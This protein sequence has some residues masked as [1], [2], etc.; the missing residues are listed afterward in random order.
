MIF[1]GRRFARELELQLPSKRGKLA[2]IYDPNNEAARVYTKIKEKKAK[3]LGVEFA[4][5]MMNNVQGTMDD[6]IRELDK[7]PSVDG[8]M[9]QLPYPNSAEL[10]KLID[11]KKDVDGL[12]E[13]SPFVPATVRAVLEILKL[14]T[15]PGVV[16]VVGGRGEVGKRLLR[17][18]PGALGMDKDDFD[19]RK[20]KRA[21]VVIS[22]TGREG[23][24]KPEMVKDGVVAIDV[25]Y[26]K[27][28]FD[29]KVAEKAAFFTPV[30]GGVGPVT[31]ACLFK[32]LLEGVR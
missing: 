29:A 5:F 8:I 15:T 9:I 32:N 30:P 21:D 10:I 14:S 22:C 19:V 23:L 1:D 12:R 25:G 3:E 31:V 13:D 17:E 11:A 26:P 18:L 6:L 24:I 7:D 28:D 16:L 27:G 2:V 4:K 20:I